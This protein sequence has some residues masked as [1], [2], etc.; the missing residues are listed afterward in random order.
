[1]CL[2]S[3]VICNYRELSTTAG[4]FIAVLLLCWINGVDIHKVMTAVKMILDK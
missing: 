1:M 3:I 4:F 2:Q